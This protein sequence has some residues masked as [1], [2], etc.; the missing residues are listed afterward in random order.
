[1][2]PLE[3]RRAMIE[4][5]PEGKFSVYRQCEL[6]SI[7]RSGLY[8]SPRA[9]SQENLDIMLQMDQQYFKTPFYGVRRMHNWL[10]KKGYVICRK[11]V[12][13]LMDLMGWQTIYRKRNT[14]KPN[15][16]NPVFPYL[17]KG[18]NIERANQVWAIDI[19]YIPM[20]K[21]FMYLCAVIDVHTRYVLNWSVSNTMTSAWCRTVVEEA[22]LQNGAPEII[23]SDQ[24]SQFTS[25]EYTSL[26][27]DRANPIQ[28]SMDGKG[29]A[30]DNIFIERLWKTVKYE[31]VYLHTFE[32]GVK[33]YEGL[34][35]YFNFYNHER[36]HQSLGYQTPADM[37]RTA[38]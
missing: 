29:R 12:K 18:L 9:E 20:R 38:A 36:D 30:I 27:L 33:L 8:Y 6:L 34:S 16:A 19:T 10:C 14:S 37:Y 5:K 1:M 2:R 11:R 13:R 23:N 31:C 4:S 21:G 15:K 25:L 32:D 26:L 7:H 3:E 28:I 22:I 35:N 17:L 24:G